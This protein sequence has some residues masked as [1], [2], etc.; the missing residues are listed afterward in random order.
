MPHSK[1]IYIFLAVFWN[2]LA[3]RITITQISQ[4]ST[5]R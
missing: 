3:Q 1:E 5:C 2:V 4:T